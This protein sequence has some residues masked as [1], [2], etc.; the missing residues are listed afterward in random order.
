M[1]GGTLAGRVASACTE[2]LGLQQRLPGPSS[3]GRAPA[4]ETAT[5]DRRAAC[6]APGR[7]QSAAPQG[8]RD[9]TAWPGAR[10]TRREL[11][12]GGGRARQL[13]ASTPSRGLV[14]HCELFNMSTRPSLSSQPLQAGA[15]G[16][17]RRQR[18]EAGQVSRN[19]LLAGARCK[20]TEDGAA[21]TSSPCVGIAC[22]CL[23]TADSAPHH[24]TTRRGTQRTR[25]ERSSQM[26]CQ[27]W[28]WY[29]QLVSC[30]RMLPASAC[31]PRRKQLQTHD[32]SPAC[33]ARY[34]T[35]QIL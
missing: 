1:R 5:G 27:T 6:P 22:R 17:F 31:T 19:G 33:Y 15:S 2:A 20:Q 26:P 4:G 12:L 18:G 23:R 9:P 29:W 10:R 25:R 24:P 28:P 13:Q 8:A 32:R 30:V 35:S 21:V 14:A 7:G 11:R 34:T 3:R 16:A